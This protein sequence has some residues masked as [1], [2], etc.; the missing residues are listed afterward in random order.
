MSNKIIFIT[1]LIISF[2]QILHIFEEIALN[3]FDLTKGKNPRGK[4]LRIASVLVTL[5]FVVLFLLYL[6][7]VIA[8]YFAFYTV[9]I[10]AGNMIAH[11]LLFRR[12]RDKLGYAL[13]SSI[14][15]GLAGF[16]L[17]FCLLKYFF[18]A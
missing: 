14:P 10:S 13:P 8:Y 18:I 11:I 17:L 5:N 12:H 9:I 1:V 3:A 6:E 4:Y 15:L 7:Y 16:F 2:L